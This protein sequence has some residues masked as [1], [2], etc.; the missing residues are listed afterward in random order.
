MAVTIDNHDSKNLMTSRGG[1]Q[2]ELYGV[3]ASAWRFVSLTQS[4]NA[5]EAQW[6]GQPRNANLNGDFVLFEDARNQRAAACQPLA[7]PSP[8]A[9]HCAGLRADLENRQP[10]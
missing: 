6:T 3:P 8:D 7:N 2:D 10:G 5:Q 9:R 4:P 1:R